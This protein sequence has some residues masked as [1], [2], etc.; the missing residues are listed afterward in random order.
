MNLEQLKIVQA[1]YE[2][3]SLSSAAKQLLRSPSAI[4]LNLK[5]LEQEWGIAIFDRSQYRLTLTREGEEV[6]ARIQA[7]LAETQSLQ[8]YV[9]ALGSGPEISL[10]ICIDKIF[11]FVQIESL[12]K[13]FKQQFPHTHLYLSVKE[14]HQPH[15]LLIERQVDL[16]VAVQGFVE[17]D[18]IE[19]LPLLTLDFIPVAAKAYIDSSEVTPKHL[20]QKTQIIIG[21]FKKQDVGVAGIQ[22]GDSK[23]SVTD[24]A[25]KKSLI[26]QG[27]GYG[28]MPAYL[29]EDELAAGALVEISALQK[30]QAS[31]VLARNTEMAMGPA[32]SFLWQAL[33]D[34]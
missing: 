10:K 15:D 16:A 6:L 3:G 26:L 14:R 32:K 4:S 1:I 12:L 9:K 5:N 19:A 7:I 28:Y 24:L 2:T 8:D 22:K 25:T 34:G 20:E 11:P 18:N 13:T 23:W 27:L 21:E 31:F 33:T 17:A 29:I 30:R